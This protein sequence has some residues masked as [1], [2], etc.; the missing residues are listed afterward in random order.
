MKLRGNMAEEQK[1]EKKTKRPSAQKRDIQSQKR[2]LKNRAFKSSVRTAIR[3]LD[4]MIAKKDQA[5]LHTK[6]N[7]IYSILDK[8][9]KL[10]VLK[11]NQASRTKSRL[12]A[13]TAIASS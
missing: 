1:Q 12:A 10:G 6:L 9:V 7:D 3:S 5:S 8:G 13:R 4:E 2:R 11:L